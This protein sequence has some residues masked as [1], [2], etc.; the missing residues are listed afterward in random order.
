M[1]D[2]LCAHPL[3]W[4]HSP[5]AVDLAVVLHVATPSAA[6]P[7]HPILGGQAGMEDQQCD[8]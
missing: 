5:C 1:D 2:E 8:V 3:P 7:N 4:L 6:K